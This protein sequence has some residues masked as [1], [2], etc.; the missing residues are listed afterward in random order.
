[1]LLGE[2]TDRIIDFLWDDPRPLCSCAL[3]CR[4]WHAASR[5]QLYREMW[6]Q[7]TRSFARMFNYL[8][9]PESKPPFDLVQSLH[10]CESSEKTISLAFQVLFELNG[11]TRLEVF[12]LQNASIAASLPAVSLSTVASLWVRYRSYAIPP[13]T[14]CSGDRPP[15]LIHTFWRLCRACPSL[16]YASVPLDARR[17]FLKCYVG[18]HR[19]PPLGPCDL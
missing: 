13:P 19:H 7:S 18:L 5:F 6:I 9:M 3:I 10:L 1:M 12:H 2:L 16:S 8:K 4:E 14:I 11:L 17:P 15:I